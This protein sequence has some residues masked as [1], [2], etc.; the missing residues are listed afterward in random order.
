MSSDTLYCAEYHDKLIN[1][2]KT[3][4]KQK[5]VAYFATKS[6]YFGVGGGVRDF[7]HRIRTQW[8]NVF[9]TKTVKRFVDGLEREILAVIKE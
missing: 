4:L 1:L 7:E 9:E 2:I 3:L 5:G 6:Y 8:G